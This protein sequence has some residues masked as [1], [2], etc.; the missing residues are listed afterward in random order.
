[1]W[2]GTVPHFNGLGGNLV[3]IAAA[4]VNALAD[5]A[6]HQRWRNMPSLSCDGTRFKQQYHSVDIQGEAVPLMTVFGRNPDGTVHLQW[7]SKLIFAPTEPGQDMRHLGT[8]EPVW[9]LF[10]LRPE[11]R[12]V[13]NEQHDYS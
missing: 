4:P 6:R 5:V 11:G 7:A 2:D 8:V 13:A 3:I 12:P 10:D 1:M 9:T